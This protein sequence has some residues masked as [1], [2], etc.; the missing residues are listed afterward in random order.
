[1]NALKEMNKI[2]IYNRESDRSE[3]PA[4]QHECVHFDIGIY[5]KSKMLR[6]RLERRARFL[7]A[8]A[9]RNS[10]PLTTNKLAT[11]HLIMRDSKEMSTGGLFDKLAPGL[12]LNRDTNE[13]IAFLEKRNSEIVDGY[14][15]QEL[16]L[17][18]KESNRLGSSGL[19]DLD[20]EDVETF[21]RSD[22]RNRKQELRSGNWTVQRRRAVCTFKQSEGSGRE[23]P[24]GKQF[25]L[26][27]NQRE[28]S[29]ERT[30]DEEDFRKRNIWIYECGN[31]EFGC[32]EIEYWRNRKGKC[33]SV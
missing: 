33:F 17:H 18:D 10:P 22:P 4:A 14:A 32:E 11:N 8:K 7:F 9:K 1:M 30:T 29:T 15:K 27:R 19:R 3:N 2:L 21:G 6:C 23:A 5:E 20:K 26:W 13:K 12:N 31:E 16:K 28:V 25:Q 24:D